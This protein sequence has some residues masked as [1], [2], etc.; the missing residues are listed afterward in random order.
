[1]VLLKSRPGLLLLVFL[2]PVTLF[3]Q[4]ERGRIISSETGS[5]I[6]FANIG[7]LGKNQGTVSNQDGNFALSI[8]NATDK[9][10]IRFSMI[11]YISKTIS[12]SQF[13]EDSLKNVTLSPVAY[14]IPEIEVTYHKPKNLRLGNS[15]QTN[16]LRSG[17]SSNDLGS[18][19]GV[20][21]YVRKKV[22][23]K[24][25][26]LDVA[27]CTY[28]SVTYRL[29][30]YQADVDDDYRNILKEPIYISFSKDDIKKVITSN[31]LKYSI[32]V[33]G[34]ILITLELYKDMGEGRLLFRTEYFT[35]LTYHRKTSEGN[36]TQSPGVIGMYLNG[37]ILN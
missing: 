5:G 8:S 9:D 10:S 31:L 20:M 30:I 18:E 16:Y 28:D 21:V 4:T 7:L 6:G 13:K 19:L 3:S 1:M 27:V 22:V 15:V 17:F 2:I 24:N 23:L 33:E 12:V 32:T 37:I 25:I 14:S 11:G 36:W 34:N 35:G 26:N 29:N